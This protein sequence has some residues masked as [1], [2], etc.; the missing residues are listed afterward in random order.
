MTTPVPAP[1]GAP[2]PGHSWAGG[3][4]FAIFKASKQ[5]DAAWKLVEFL[6][7]R[8]IQTRFYALSGD[9]PARREAWDDAPLAGDAKAR[10][11]REQADHLVP[12]PRVPEWEQIAQRMQEDMEAAI[13]GRETVPASL[14]RLDADVDR[15]LEKRR[16]I[17]SRRRAEQPH[18]R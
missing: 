4:S 1:D 12:L 15:I 14:A 5:K 17:L 7:R 11:F 10:A 13:R 2:W 18:G 6:S 16:W 9:L 8:E 3:A